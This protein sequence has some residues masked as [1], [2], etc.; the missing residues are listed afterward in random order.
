MMFAPTTP[1]CFDTIGVFKD[2]LHKEIIPTKAKILRGSDYR[3]NSKI[4][5]IMRTKSIGI[6]T[7]VN[8]FTLPYVGK[9]VDAPLIHNLASTLYNGIDFKFS[10]QEKPSSSVYV[11]NQ[12][13]NK[14]T[15]IDI[16]NFSLF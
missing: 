3:I 4:E 10:A 8:S 12:F 5:Q 14:K 11:N 7:D 13:E 16:Q 9:S 15:T 2:F 6:L 1:V